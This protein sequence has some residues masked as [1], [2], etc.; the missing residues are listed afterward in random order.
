MKSSGYFDLSHSG[1]VPQEEGCFPTLMLHG[2][3]STAN[4]IS[5]SEVLG[6]F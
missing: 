4:A 6:F 3:R 2:R 5:M 1:D